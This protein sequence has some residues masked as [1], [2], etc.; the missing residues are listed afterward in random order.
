MATLHIQYDTPLDTTTCRNRLSALQSQLAQRYGAQCHW[1]DE[2][3]LI[4]HP[5]L[6]GNISL[7]PG[8][9]RLDATLKFPLSLMQNKIEQELK[10]LLATH[11]G[12]SP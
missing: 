4:S 9:I 10:Q 2:Q 7:Q 6:T 11:F 12:T 5:Q 3:C 1:Q 8:T